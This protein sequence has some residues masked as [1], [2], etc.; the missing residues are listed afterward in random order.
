[1]CK[2]VMTSLSD[3]D[4]YVIT[5]GDIWQSATHRTG[6]VDVYL[7]FGSV[8]SSHLCVPSLH[9]CG[10]VG[11]SVK[12]QQVEIILI[13]IFDLWQRKKLSYSLLTSNIDLGYFILQRSLIFY[14]LLI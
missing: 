2:I 9:L 11:R 3:A 12:D 1:M 5:Y 6:S 13:T 8:D 10:M 4:D 7:L 14:R